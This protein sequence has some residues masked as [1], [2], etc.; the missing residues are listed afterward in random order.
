MNDSLLIKLEKELHDQSS[1]KNAIRLNYLLHK[2]FQEFG[3]SGRI[4]TKESVIKDLLMEKT[5]LILSKDFKVRLLTDTL[6]QVTYRSLNTNSNASALRSSLW[7]FEEDRWQ[8][9]FHQGTPCM[10]Y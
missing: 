9:I 6:A 4:F 2:D 10:A 5:T 8:L 3:Q 7:V 1:R